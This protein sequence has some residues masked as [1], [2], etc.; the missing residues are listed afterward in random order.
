MVLKAEQQGQSATLAVPQLGSCASSG[1][2]WRLWAARHSQEEAGPLGAQP[3]PQVLEP[4]A[5]KAAHCTVPPLTIQA[6]RAGVPPNVKLDGCYKFVD[7]LNG[8]IPNGPPSMIKCD[9]LTIEGNMILEAGVVFEGDAKVLTT[10]YL[11]LSTYYLHY[12][13]YLLLTTYYSLRTRWSTPRPRPRRSR[14]APTRAPS[15]S[16][17][18]QGAS[19]CFVL[20]PWVRRA[21]S[22]RRRF[23][24]VTHV[25]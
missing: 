24:R 22:T 3:L 20:G 8:L 7:G 1:R 21:Q 16:R 10:Y 4:A 13:H 17:R 23:R 15:S 19:G 9:K 11:P 2:L 5:S 18:A 25:P 6:E 12:L 14:R